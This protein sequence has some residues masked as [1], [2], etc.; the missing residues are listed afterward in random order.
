LKEASLYEKL[1]GS[2]VKCQ[3]C[4]HNCVISAGKRGKCAVRENIDGILY[5]L[6]YGKLCSTAIDPIEKK[7]LFHFLP[8]SQTMSIATVGCNLKCL[9]CQNYSISQYPSYHD[10]NITGAIH[11]PIDIVRAALDNNCLSISYT[12]TEP[13][14]FMEFALDSARLA[15]DHGLKNIFVSN[16]FM[17]AQ[18]AKE[19]IP[20][21]D[22]NNIDLKGD[23]EFY[24]NICKARL[25]P[26]QDT[27]RLMKSSGVWV[28]VTTLIIPGLNDSEK[29][30]REIAG[31]I[32]SVDTA[33]PWHVSSFRPTYKLTDRPA[34]SMNTLR[35]AYEIGVG[36]GLKYVYV[37]NMPGLG[38][39][40]TYC[41]KCKTVLIKR[42]G[43]NVI[44]N[45]VKDGKC[46]ECGGLIEGVL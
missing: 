45:K 33:I 6:V 8:G 27:I 3:L 38:G 15:H 31:F 20:F 11:S 44:S 30:L 46:F 1:E 21:L 12:Y 36:A 32:H 40:D 29:T 34:T 26:V 19:I 37:G 5:T 7:P 9:H 13:T 22:A 24:K 10:G 18:G 39:E 43:F 14:I 23:D 17:S 25:A 28:E 16:G 35:K 42:H 4:A 41:P 2:R